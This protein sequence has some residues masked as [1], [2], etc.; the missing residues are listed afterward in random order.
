MARRQRIHYPGALYHVMLRGNAKQSIFED[1][2]D[3]SRFE[4]ILDQSAEKCDLQIYA[5]C[6]MP[7][8]IHMAVQVSRT[9]LSKMMQVLSQR[10]TGW[11]N[12]RHDRV[13]HLFQGRYKAILVDARAYLMELIRYIHLNPVRAGMVKDIAD[14]DESSHGAYLE[15]ERAARWLCVDPALKFFGPSESSARARYLD[16]MGQQVDEDQLDLLRKGN[17][18]GHILGDDV[19]VHRVMNQPDVTGVDE[20]PGISGISGTSDIEIETLTRLVAEKKE[21]AEETVFSGSRNRNA[22]EA[23]ALIALLAVDHTHHGLNDVAR[24]LNRDSSTLCKQ[25]N[26]LRNRR[27]KFAHINAEIEK[28]AAEISQ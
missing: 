14:Y 11:V 1:Q 28:L 27:K 7:N 5:Y 13:G 20:I 16:F 22:S 12:N 9:P 15:P 23:R 18:Q 4:Y 25:V 10:Y 26:R 3:I 2:D 21:V 6:W 17:Q 19:F 8:H 24:Y